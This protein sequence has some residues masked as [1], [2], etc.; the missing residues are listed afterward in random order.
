MPVFFM[1]IFNL[2]PAVNMVAEILKKEKNEE[3]GLEY[4]D[5]RLTFAANNPVL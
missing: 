3:N 5:N 4:K 1:V 2:L